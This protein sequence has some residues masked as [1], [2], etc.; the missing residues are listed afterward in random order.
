MPAVLSFAKRSRVNVMGKAYTAQIIYQPSQHAINDAKQ[1]AQRYQVGDVIAVEPITMHNTLNSATGEWVRNSA[2]NPKFLY[3]NVTGVPETIDYKRL[4]EEARTDNGSPIL[5]E[6]QENPTVRQRMCKFN[7]N[8]SLLSQANEQ[9]I[10]DDGQITLTF[11]EFKE[12]AQRKIVS[13]SLDS[14]SD[15]KTLLIDQDIE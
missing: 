5:L 15:T 14:T 3:I 2:I 11:V 12:V 10:V 6:V 13:N 1:H 9:S 7:V 8:L 4:V